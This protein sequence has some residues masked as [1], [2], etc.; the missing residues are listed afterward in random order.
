[1]VPSLQTYEIYFYYLA[2]YLIDLY[3]NSIGHPIQIAKHQ[4]INT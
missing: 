1:M 2:Y 4:I 3:Q